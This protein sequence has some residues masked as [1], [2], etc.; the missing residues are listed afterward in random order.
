MVSK[1]Y[2]I[3]DRYKNLEMLLDDPEIPEDIVNS[4]VEGVEGE[5]Q[6]KID[7]LI[8]ITKNMDA[9]IA[10]CEAE[11][12]RLKERR[13]NIE[14]KKDSIRNYIQNQMYKINLKK[15]NTPLFRV[16]IKANQESVEIF[17]IEDIPKDYFILKPAEVS[18]TLIKEA[19]QKGV[20]I[21]G[22]TLI[23]TESL[24]IK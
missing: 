2:E 10:A 13:K 16:V 3:A 6:E 23:R 11:E 1:L 12:K 20:Q 4:A 17:N 18:K 14:K 9:D 15:I 5:F 24:Q 21:P 22:A 7:Y 8:R 19:L